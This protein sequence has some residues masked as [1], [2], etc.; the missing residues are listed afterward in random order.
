MNSLLGDPPAAAEWDER[1]QVPWPILQEAAKI[2][3][4]SLDF[5]A[6]PVLRGVGARHPGG[7]RGAVL[8]RRRHRAV[9]RGQRAGRHRG[10]L[11][12]HAGA[13]REWLRTVRHADDVKLGAFCSIGAG[14][15]QR[16]GRDPHPGGLRREDRRVGHQ[17]GEDL[18]HQRRHRQRARRR[19]LGRPVARIARAGDVHRAAG[20]PGCRWARSSASTAS[21]PRT[22]PRSSSTT[23]GCPGRCLVGG[24][25]KLDHRLARI[26]EGGRGGE[27][28]AMK[29]FEA[30]RPSVAA[31]AVGV[32]RAATESRPSTRGPGCSSG[33]RSGRTR[34]WRS[35]SRTWPPRSTRPGC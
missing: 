34:A 17:R 32:A 22:R 3:L 8:G 14:R 9:H 31:M 29:T 5:L 7:V 12:R 18:G 23:C 25:E 1:E 27:Q 20:H 30:S 2:G 19:R 26:R 33:G 15:G 35:S 16:R 11:Q 4:Y 13:D 21:G 6:A 24:K 28:A 10:R